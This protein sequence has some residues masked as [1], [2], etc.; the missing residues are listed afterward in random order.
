MSNIPFSQFAELKIVI[1]TIKAVEV[2]PEADR[3]LK[4]SVDVGEEEER[5]IISG[6]R[7]YFA[8]EQVLVGRQCPFVTN[9]EPRKIRGYTSNGMILA[10]HV[11][12]TLSL[13]EPNP[14]VPAGTPVQ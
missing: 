10:T 2:V 13:L 4:L 7:T 11:D 3:L 14:A 6:I 5:Q 8:D 12:E 9:L 1:G